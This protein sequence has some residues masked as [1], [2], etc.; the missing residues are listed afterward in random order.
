MDL[1]PAD[2]TIEQRIDD[3]LVGAI[4]P[5]VHTGP[6]IAARSVDHLE[7][8]REASCIDHVKRCDAR[9]QPSCEPGATLGGDVCIS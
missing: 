4:D 1:A 8:A 3:L 7:M 5:H 2:K 6:S 9:F